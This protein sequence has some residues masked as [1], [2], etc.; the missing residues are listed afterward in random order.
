MQDRRGLPL[1]NAMERASRRTRLHMPGHFGRMPDAGD[2]LCWTY[3]LTEVEG[4]DSLSAPSGV[5][6]DLQARTAAAYGAGAAW[7]SVQGATLPVLAGSLAWAPRGARVEIPRHAH[8]SVLAAALLGEWDVRWVSAPTDPVFGVPLP[9]SRD[10]WGPPVEALTRRLLVSPTY[11]GI[12]AEPPTGPGVTLFVDAAHGGHFGRH[13][14][15]PPHALR[16]G[17]DFAAHGLHKTEP[18]LTQSGLLLARHTDPGGAVERWWRVLGT[19][20]PSYLLLAG[21]EAYVRAREDGDG[22]WGAYTDWARELWALAERRG[23]RVL[24]A[25]EERRGLRVDPAK[26]TVAAD[27]AAV[28]ERLGAAGFTPEAVGPA[29][30]TFIMGPQAGLL[31][32]DGIRLLDALGPPGVPAVTAFYP[33][34][35]PRALQIAQAF[36]MP[37]HS[38]PLS[39]VEGLVAAEALTPYPPGI[40]LVVP[41]EILHQDVLDYV[42]EL[43]RR[44]TMIEGLDQ[45]QG[46][47]RVWVVDA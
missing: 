20:S 22:G 33:D 45:G 26:F 38:M 7:L 16:E 27:G 24:Q 43:T 4:L 12:V 18:V 46:G 11:E 34:I 28:A 32:Q 42:E 21:L 3:D 31:T 23:H 39:D 25:Q 41:G 36:H 9:P 19:S 29:S 8:R 13:V 47:W 35:P 5:L 37:R 14:S 44:G 30:V 6:Q 10:M 40:P 2:F 1:R 17:A 15:L